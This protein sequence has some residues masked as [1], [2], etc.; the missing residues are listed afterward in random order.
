M[1]RKIKGKI[2]RH[3]LEESLLYLTMHQ[4]AISKKEYVSYQIKGEKRDIN[5]MGSRSKR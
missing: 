3:E 4:N 2:K 5:I 1:M